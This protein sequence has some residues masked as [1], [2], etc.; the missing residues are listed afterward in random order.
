M[1]ATE[2]P[3]VALC[4][5]VSISAV[6]VPAAHIGVHVCFICVCYLHVSGPEGRM[7][8]LVN[9]R[10]HMDLDSKVTKVM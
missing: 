7:Q 3:C 5:H 10:K 6:C 2:E 8:F 4:L 1:G 9:K